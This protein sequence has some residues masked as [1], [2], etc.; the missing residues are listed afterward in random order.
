MTPLE[1]LTLEMK[2]EKTDCK[3]PLSVAG[4]TNIVFLKLTEQ[5]PPSSSSVSV[6]NI[7]V[8]FTLGYTYLS[9]YTELYLSVAHSWH[10]FN[11]P[12]GLWLQ[13]QGA[14]VMSTFLLE[15]VSCKETMQVFPILFSNFDLELYGFG[16]LTFIW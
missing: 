7:F 15:F 4:E 8:P 12:C 10:L 13:N 3:T 5:H 1:G 16:F 9:A 2:L 11:C 6:L 14:T